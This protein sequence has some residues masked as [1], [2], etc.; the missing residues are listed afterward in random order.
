MYNVYLVCSEIEGKKLYKI[1][2]T[3]REVEKR[4]KEFKTGNASE[5]YIIDSFQ[6]KWGTKIESQLHK[7]Y[8]PKKVSGEWFDLNQEELDNFLKRCKTIH[9]NLELISTQNTFYLDRQSFY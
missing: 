9:D 4:I 6:S 7:F 2:Y 3:R 5:F 8:K 1:G